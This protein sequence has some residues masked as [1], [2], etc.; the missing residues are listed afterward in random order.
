MMER[1]FDPIE[2]LLTKHRYKSNTVAP[3]IRLTITWNFFT[4][5]LL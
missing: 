3:M 4:E 2:Q 5:R 1:S